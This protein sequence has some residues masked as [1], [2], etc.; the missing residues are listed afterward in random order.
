[1][2]SR[3]TNIAATGAIA[4][5][6]LGTYRYLYIDSATRAFELSFDGNAWQPG[7]A[8]KYY[9]LS[10][11]VQSRVYFRAVNGLAA[12]VNFS[13]NVQ[14]FTVQSTAQSNASTYCVG[15]LGIATGASST[16]E[17]PACDVHGNLLITNAM[18]LLIEGTHEGNQR[19]MITFAVDKSSSASLNVL[20]PDGNNFKTMN[21]GDDF[22]YPTDSIFYLSGAGGTALVSV[23]QIFL[24]S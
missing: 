20:D 17:L 18:S 9:D 12:T 4:Q 8:N 7:V 14:P 1:M 11:T 2:N 16:S 19:Q 13:Y 22:A 3:I 5:E 15:N 21:P 23:G 10:A 6:T 24:K